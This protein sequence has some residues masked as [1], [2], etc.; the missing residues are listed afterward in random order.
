[1]Q[2]TG[3]TLAQKPHP[4]Q[5]SKLLNNCA[6]APGG[7]S[8]F[9]S[10]YCNVAEGVKRCQNVKRIP[11]ST[12]QIPANTLAKYSFSAKVTISSPHLVSRR[13]RCHGL[14]R[15]PGTA[16]VYRD[17]TLAPHSPCGADAPPNHLGERSAAD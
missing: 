16:P 1:M 10:G 9:S 11:T 8:H 7:S 3:H 14:G 2:S 4:I 6:R 12:V 13:H 5:S 17:K 15:G